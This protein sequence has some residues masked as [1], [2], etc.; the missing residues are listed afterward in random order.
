MREVIDS[1]SEGMFVIGSDGRIKLWND[2][3]Q[4]ISG[5]LSEQAIG[6]TVR[7][8]LPG[9][10]AT[11]FE[12]AIEESQTTRSTISVSGLRFIG[13]YSEKLFDVRVFPFD[14]GTTVFFTDVSEKLKTE[15]T[16]RDAENRFKNLFENSPIGF[17]EAV[18]MA[19]C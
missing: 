15:A 3:A 11:R 1:I 10:D 7:E 8:A 18:W 5:R 16:L 19:R 9:L 2:A 14:G 4:K 17:I 13:M 6:N 12:L